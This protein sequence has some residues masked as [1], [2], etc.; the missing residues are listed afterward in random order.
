MSWTRRSFLSKQI[1]V[2]IF[3]IM[4]SSEMLSQSYHRVTNEQNISLFFPSVSAR[5][6]YHR[7]S[8][9]FRIGNCLQKR[10]WKGG[11]YEIIS[12]CRCWAYETSEEKTTLEK[13]TETGFNSFGLPSKSIYIVCADEDTSFAPTFPKAIDLCSFIRFECVCTLSLFSLTNNASCEAL[14]NW[15]TSCLFILFNFW[16]LSLSV[17]QPLQFIQIYRP[18]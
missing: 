11:C 12:W 16:S 4:H 1:T 2:L 14:R 17:G 8:W 13:I 5:H 10:L 18:G 3:P 15:G 6:D 7:S 9:S